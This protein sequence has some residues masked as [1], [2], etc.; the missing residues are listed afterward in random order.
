MT[1]IAR[2]RIDERTP[3]RIVRR[4]I[5]VS[6]RMTLRMLARTI[7][8]ACGLWDEKRH[9]RY[10]IGEATYS[11][12]PAGDGGG[13]ACRTAM[14]RR[15][16]QVL[17][18]APEFVFVH[19]ISRNRRLN[20]EVRAIVESD[21]PETAFPRL[22]DAVGAIEIQAL[23]PDDGA[24]RLVVDAGDPGSFRHTHAVE[25]W[26]DEEARCKRDIR[27]AEMNVDSLRRRRRGP[28]R[29]HQAGSARH[30][31]RG[32]P[33]EPSTEAPRFDR[34]KEQAREPLG[35]M[36]DGRER[37]VTI[38]DG[39]AVFE[40][41][42][43]T[44]LMREVAWRWT[45]DRDDGRDGIQAAI[46]ENGKLARSGRGDLCI[47]VLYAVAL[48]AGHEWKPARDVY[49]QVVEAAA[50][51]LPD[52]FEGPVDTTTE[53]GHAVVTAI[54]LLARNECDYGSSARG[55]KAYERSLAWD[56]DP[57][58]EARLRLGSEYIKAHRLKDARATIAAHGELRASYLYDLVLADVM[59]R[60]WVDAVT[61]ARRALAFGP[62]IGE[63]ILGTRKPLPMP[64]GHLG[65]FRSLDEARLYVSRFGYAWKVDKTAKALLRWV[66]THPEAVR[67][68]GT[69]R[70]PDHAGALETDKEQKAALMAEFR[71]RVASA[72][73]A[74]SRRMLDKAGSGCQA[75]LKT[76]P[77]ATPKTDPRRNGVCR[78]TTTIPWSMPTATPRRR[79]RSAAP[80]PNPGRPLRSTS[81]RGRPGRPVQAGPQG[82]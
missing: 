49:R 56:E 39:K 43:V 73:P 41:D 76:D 15:I 32:V 69:L 3:T 34:P 61:H 14:Q 51:A 23:T 6:T 29:S 71:R 74:L 82:P 78:S 12:G 53:T 27:A 24:H 60:K 58:N 18:E 25:L 72:P 9:W 68:R 37:S 67:E 40:D 26:H 77:L 13:S 5:K 30:G 31:G 2:L 65:G 20:V 17:N 80:F 63:I 66:A 45:G 57:L 81:R 33:R 79:F 21:E 70:E 54:E 46:R 52:G 16:E 10:E 4:D 42:P 7:R 19:N 36:T 55:V 50:A 75:T 11:S 62:Y 22:T 35:L 38:V 28:L 59:E 64:M 1:T 44:V 48:E 47:A 8:A